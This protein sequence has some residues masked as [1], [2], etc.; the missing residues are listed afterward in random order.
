MLDRVSLDGA[1]IEYSLEI[2]LINGDSLSLNMETM[3]DA[4]RSVVALSLMRER[5]LTTPESISLK[6]PHLRKLAL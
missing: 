2:H 6:S 3:E 5:D 4:V 1:N